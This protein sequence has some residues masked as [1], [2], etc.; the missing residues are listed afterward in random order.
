MKY[1]A[2]I[3]THKYKFLQDQKT[4]VREGENKNQD[5]SAQILSRATISGQV[6]L[7]QLTDMCELWLVG[8]VVIKKWGWNANNVRKTYS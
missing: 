8:F 1:S 5:S 4:H 3:I 2:S 6:S 7:I